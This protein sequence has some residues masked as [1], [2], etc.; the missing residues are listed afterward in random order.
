MRLAV[1]LLLV[2]CPFF[3]ISARQRR[4]AGVTGVPE[5]VSALGIHPIPT[6]P[7]S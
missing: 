6:M 1:V 7:V 4:P 5:P 2:L 3:C